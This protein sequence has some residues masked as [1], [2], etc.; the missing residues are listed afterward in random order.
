[1]SMKK[2]PI[3]SYRS[4]ATVFIA[5]KLGALD[6]IRAFVVFLTVLFAIVMVAGCSNSDDSGGSRRPSRTSN[7]SGSTG[8]GGDD[9]GGSTDTDNQCGD[10]G[11]C[12]ADR[13]CAAIYSCVKTDFCDHP[14]CI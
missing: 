11:E 6:N 14:I 7:D 4:K 5:H 12:G 13:V 9:G 1:M 8:G 3:R 2:L 10:W